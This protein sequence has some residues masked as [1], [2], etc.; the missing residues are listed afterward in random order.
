MR[1]RLALPPVRPSVRGRPSVPSAIASD[2]T[3]AAID[4][5]A[6]LAANYLL[7]NCP[8]NLLRLQSGGERDYIASVPAPAPAPALPPARN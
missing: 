6:L 5:S 8:E 1:V 2:A 4:A 3:D 7:L